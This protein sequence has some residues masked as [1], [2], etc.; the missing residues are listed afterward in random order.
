MYICVLVININI[1][2]FLLIAWA[3]LWALADSRKA[4]SIG[5][6][7]SNR[8]MVGTNTDVFTFKK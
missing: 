2:L 7:N 3:V 6:S 1:K 4:L 5:G 8:L